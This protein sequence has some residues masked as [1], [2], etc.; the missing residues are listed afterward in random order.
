V[1]WYRPQPGELAIVRLP[2]G[3]MATVV[4]A[5]G[6]VQIRGEDPGRAA[7]LDEIAAE[8]GV[9]PGR[10]ANVRYGFVPYEPTAA[11]WDAQLRSALYGTTAARCVRGHK[12]DVHVWTEARQL[13]K[14]TPAVYVRI[15]EIP[16]YRHSRH[17][18]VAVRPASPEGDQ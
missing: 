3:E 8:L 10:D 5:A 16:Y 15:E 1:S 12:L 4:A 9:R 11:G 18:A 13:L 7:A 14:G 6:P 2:P 17:A